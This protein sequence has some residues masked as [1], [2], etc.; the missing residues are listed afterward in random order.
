LEMM[1]LVQRSEVKR[2]AP[3]KPY[4]RIRREDLSKMSEKELHELYAQTFE[5]SW[6]EQASNISDEPERP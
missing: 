2:H 5:P 3:E 6:I 4:E 1:E